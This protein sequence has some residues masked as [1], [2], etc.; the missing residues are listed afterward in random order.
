MVGRF[1]A[2]TGPLI[3]GGIVYLLEGSGSRAYRAAIASLLVM[4]V[5]GAAVLRKVEE[6]GPAEAIDT[7]KIAPL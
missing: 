7:P 4:I 3:W 2:I 6:P 1:S 5:A